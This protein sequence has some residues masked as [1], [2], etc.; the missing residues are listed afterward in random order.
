V[1]TCTSLLEPRMQHRALLWAPGAAALR[2][3][4]TTTL[5]FLPSRPSPLGMPGVLHMRTFT[6]G[7]KLSRSV[8]Q[9]SFNILLTLMRPSADSLVRLSPALVV[10]SWHVLA[11]DDSGVNGMMVAPMLNAAQAQHHHRGH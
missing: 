3:A 8:P 7:F 9:L 2:C 11:L 5:H 6:P 1:T 4:C 10:Y